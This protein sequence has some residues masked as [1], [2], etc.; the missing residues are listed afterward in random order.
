MLEKLDE[1]N[2]LLYAAK[3]WYEDKSNTRLKN[4]VMGWL[5]WADQV[6]APRTGALPPVLFFGNSLAIGGHNPGVQALIGEAALWANLSGGDPAITFRWIK[7]TLDYLQTQ[8]VIPG[9]PM[10][11]SWSLNQSTFAGTLKEY[12][13]WWHGACIQFYS[14]L[15]A[16]KALITYPPCSEPLSITVTSPPPTVCC[17]GTI[18]TSG[19]GSLLNGS[20]PKAS[21]FS[22]N[23]MDMLINQESSGVSIA[24]PKSLSQWV[25]IVSSGTINI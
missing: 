14:N 10:S 9:N 22:F 19:I 11:G 2:A 21:T 12:Y 25:S 16:N 1:S 8:F 23:R 13:S 24:I 20:T 3:A 4:L 5:Q 18:V 15:A 17:G 7:R 6:Y